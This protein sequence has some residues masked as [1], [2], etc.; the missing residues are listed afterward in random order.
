MHFPYSVFG[1]GHF[2]LFYHNECLPNHTGSAPSWILFIKKRF[3][4]CYYKFHE[5]E[6]GIFFV[7]KLLLPPFFIFLAHYLFSGLGMLVLLLHKENKL[8]F[9]LYKFM[10][11]FFFFFKV[12]KSLTTM[13]FIFQQRLTFILISG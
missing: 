11:E 6:H 13:I 7:F 1:A 9:H 8:K 2:W 10:E 12:F 4:C 3:F 5:Y